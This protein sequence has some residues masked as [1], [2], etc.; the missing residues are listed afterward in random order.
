LRWGL[1]GATPAGAQ[2]STS[3]VLVSLASLISCSSLS[4]SVIG[5]LN[6]ATG[7]LPLGSVH[8]GSESG[9]RHRLD[10]LDDSVRTM[11]GWL[12]KAIRL[13]GFTPSKWKD[14]HD[15]VA[16]QFLST[17]DVRKLVAFMTVDGELCLITA[18]AAFPVA[19]R[20]FCFWVRRDSLHLT[21]ANIKSSIQFGAVNGGGVDSLMRVMSDVYMPTMAAG[22]GAGWPDSVRKDFVSQMQRFMASLVEAS[23]QA[24]GKTVLYLPPDEIG[25]TP[26]I[27]AAQA[28]DKDLVQRLDAC[29]IHWTHQI[30]EV[31][32]RV[33]QSVPG[34]R[35][36]FLAAAGFPP[37]VLDHF[38]VRCRLSRTRTTPQAMQSLAGLWTRSSSGRP[39]RRICP[40]SRRS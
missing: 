32:A 33:A 28:T 12:V 22:G 10:A 40:A 6:A 34:G 14:E 20:Q 5:G 35:R 18:Y 1:W 7:I 38:H 31:R 23:H 25:G 17:S 11:I 4:R 2:Q 21:P 26:E 3:V 29:V 30:K 27:T 15:N 39:A 24:K 36:G 37:L 19:P 8:S 9:R 13:K 16:A